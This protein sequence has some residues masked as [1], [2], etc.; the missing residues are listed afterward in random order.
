MCGRYSLHSH[1]DVIALQFGLRSLPAFAP[2]YNIA[3]S[4]AILAVRSDGAA[5]LRWNPKPSNAR[6]ETVADK[7]AFRD[8]YRK[9]RCLVPADGFFEWKALGARKQPYYIRPA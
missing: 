3:P 1:P 8:A 7:P 9:R 4:A 2:R 6:A 5:L